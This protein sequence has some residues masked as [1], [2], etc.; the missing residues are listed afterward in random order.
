M[1]LISFKT[2][3][4]ESF[5]IYTN[6]GVIDAGIKFKKIF[7]DLKSLLEKN[8]LEEI[9]KI[10]NNPVDYSFDDIS[11]LPPIP[12]AGKIICVG[13]NYLGHIKETGREVPNYPVLFSRFSDSF[14]GHN[15]SLVRP[16]ASID[17][18]YEGELAVIIGKKGRH[19]EEKQAM[20]HVAGYTCCNEGSIRDYQFHTMQWIP[21]KNFFRSGSMGPYIITTD[22]Q[23]DPNKFHLKTKIN[24]EILQEAPVEDLCFS[25]PKLIA[26][27][28]EWTPLNPGDILITGTPGGVGRV[29]KPPIWMKPNDIVEVDISGVGILKNTIIDE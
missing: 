20:E 3:N 24:G 29:R 6:E 15:E 19:I 8:G 27:C 10:K 14:V 22:E 12:N 23:N 28:S 7:P 26:Y 18:D 2:N 4:E 21:G 17:F 5:G 1:K 25:I 11:F 16:K 9:K 13:I